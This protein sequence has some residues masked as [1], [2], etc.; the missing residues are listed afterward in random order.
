[1]SV[2]SGTSGGLMA[3]GEFSEEPPEPVKAGKAGT[4]KKP[5]AHVACKRPAAQKGSGEETCK[6]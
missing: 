3:P 2:S 1:M 4:S 5:A 6:G